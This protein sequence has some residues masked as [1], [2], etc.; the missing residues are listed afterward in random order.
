[1]AIDCYEC[2]LNTLYICA[3]CMPAMKIIII[4]LTFWIQESC[5]TV[6]LFDSMESRFET[7]TRPSRSCFTP[8]KQIGSIAMD[9]CR[10]GQTIAPRSGK[11]VDT[12]ARIAGG[13]SSR[14]SQQCFACGDIVLLANHNIGYLYMVKQRENRRAMM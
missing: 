4:Q 14:P 9:E 2:E 12:N 8:V 11:I 1:M 6:F 13:R 7:F 3:M 5:N 10:K